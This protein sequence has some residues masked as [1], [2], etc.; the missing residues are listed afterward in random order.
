[1]ELLQEFFNPQNVKVHN[2]VEE[3]SEHIAKGVQ[4]FYNFPN[5]IREF[6]EA[7]LDRFMGETATETHLN[8]K[9]F[10]S[11]AVKEFLEIIVDDIDT[12]VNGPLDYDGA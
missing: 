1:M 3:Q 6:V 11:A 12:H 9:E 4:S 10:T 8:I 7:N 2:Y 5:E